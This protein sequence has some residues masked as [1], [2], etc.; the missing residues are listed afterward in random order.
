MAMWTGKEKL[1]LMELL[2]VSEFPGMEFFVGKWKELS[3]DP[4]KRS[5]LLNNN[6]NEE[7]D[8]FFIHSDFFLHFYKY[9][10]LTIMI[11]IY[12]HLC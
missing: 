2:Q 8:L 5:C 11:D 3:E 9:Y 12:V 6:V 10:Y 7:V 1:R 4:S